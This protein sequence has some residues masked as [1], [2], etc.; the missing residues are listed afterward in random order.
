MHSKLHDLCPDRWHLTVEV[1]KR[2]RLRSV[3]CSQ[4]PLLVW[5]FCFLGLPC[6]CSLSRDCLPWKTIQKTP[7]IF[8]PMGYSDIKINMNRVW[9]FRN[10]SLTWFHG[11]LEYALGWIISYNIYTDDDLYKHPFFLWLQSS[12]LLMLLFKQSWT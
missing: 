11:Q 1:C 7:N 3:L 10:T 5:A 6:Y 4:T 12:C 9:G 8:L 2:G